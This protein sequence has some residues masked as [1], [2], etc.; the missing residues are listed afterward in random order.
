MNPGF[1][2]EVRGMFCFSKDIRG[3]SY[4]AK[5]AVITALDVP[6]FSRRQWRLVTNG[7]FDAVCLGGYYFREAWTV[8]PAARS[9]KIPIILCTD[10]HSLENR[11][12]KS[13]VALAIKKRIVG[14]ILGR[15]PPSSPARAR[16][17]P[18]SSRLYSPR[19]HLHGEKRC[20]QYL[21]DGPCGASG[22]RW[23]ETRFEPPGRG[24]AC[25]LLRETAILEAAWG[26][27]RGILARNCS[28]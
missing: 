10:A 1:G 19:A 9:R 20:E 27:A 8:L 25:S 6:G 18:F 3:L 21:V 7:G 15:L 4:L 17:G 23:I 5:G 28:G 22:S 12:A 11:C 2:V 14:R 16:W 13:K 26:L 24:G